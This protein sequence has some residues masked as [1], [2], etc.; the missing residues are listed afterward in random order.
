MIYERLALLYMQHGKS[1][2]IL[3]EED[4]NRFEHDGERHLRLAHNIVLKGL[5]DPDTQLGQKT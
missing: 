3:D 2:S 5:N 4:R 1:G